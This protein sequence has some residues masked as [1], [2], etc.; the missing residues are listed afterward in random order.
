MELKDDPDN[1]SFTSTHLVYSSPYD[2]TNEIF[3][4]LNENTTVHL[5]NNNNNSKDGLVITTRQ[6]NSLTQRML[7]NS[8][9]GIVFSVITAILLSQTVATIK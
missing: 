6:L 7:N 5:N 9:D 1:T 8:K 4:T 3:K 2:T